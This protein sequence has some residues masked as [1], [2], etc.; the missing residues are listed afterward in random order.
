MNRINVIIASGVFALFLLSLNACVPSTGGPQANGTALDSGSRGQLQGDVAV[1]DPSGQTHVGTELNMGDYLA[2]AE[3]VTN[4]ML[5]SREVQ[6]WGNSRP[7]LILGRLVNNTDNE[8][9]RMAD[10]HDRVQETIFNSGLVKIV[11]ST[12]TDFD[13]ILKTELTST[14]QYGDDGQE[15][16]F[17]TM[18]LKM[19]KLDGELVGQWS[20]DLALG[21]GKKRLF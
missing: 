7:R 14:R 13:Y 1:L 5:A 17:F 10:L 9:I 16:A 4:N 2:F 20:D 12:A 6:S 19:F 3:K 15:L 11:D 18:Q 8:N 21:K